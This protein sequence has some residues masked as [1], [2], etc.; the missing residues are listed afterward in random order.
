MR[1]TAKLVRVAALMAAAAAGA[2]GC[3]SSSGDCTRPSP[4]TVT[5]TSAQACQ[6]IEETND[7]QAVEE[8]GY[9]VDGPTCQQVCQNALENCFLPASYVSEAHALNPD[10]GASPSDGGLLTLLCPTGP[11]TLTVTC[12]E[13]GCG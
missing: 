8:N 2:A 13:N 6:M 4:H 3:S 1:L 9:P 12:A 10:A 5:I 7:L 11:A